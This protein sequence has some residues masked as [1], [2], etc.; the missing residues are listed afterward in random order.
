MNWQGYKAEL[1]CALFICKWAVM[2]FSDGYAVS[3]SLASRLPPRGSG[4]HPHIYLITPEADKPCAIRV[5]ASSYPVLSDAFLMTLRVSII[6][7]SSK[8]E[9]PQVRGRYL[10]LFVPTACVSVSIPGAI[11]LM[12]YLSH[13]VI[14]TALGKLCLMVALVNS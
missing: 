9:L 2:L 6:R 14:K 8:T 3:E 11:A 13:Q 7:H 10:V 5:V 12:K 4:I 1:K